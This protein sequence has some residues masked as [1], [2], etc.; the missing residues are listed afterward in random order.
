MEEVD[1]RCGLVVGVD[2]GCD[3]WMWLV[4]EVGL[5][6]WRKWIVGAVRL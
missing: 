4:D 1:S 6:G 5:W 3:W 2:G